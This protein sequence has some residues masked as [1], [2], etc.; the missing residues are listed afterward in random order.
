MKTS[1]DP[2]HLYRKRMVRELFAESFTHQKYLENN[3]GDILKLLPKIDKIIKKSATAWPIDKINR[4][5]LAIL[6]FAVFEMMKKSA[7]KKVIIDEAVEIAKEY[8]SENTPSFVNGV[9]GTI[10]DKKV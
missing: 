6:R 8:G 2:R 9:L 3:A 1:L 7:P 4:I 5:D 10:Y